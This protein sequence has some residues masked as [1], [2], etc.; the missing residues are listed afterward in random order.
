[1]PGQRPAHEEVEFTSPEDWKK[2]R[3]EAQT[4][5]Q[6]H[7]A[8]SVTTEFVGKNKDV[9]LGFSAF[10]LGFS[11]GLATGLFRSRFITTVHLDRRRRDRPNARRRRTLR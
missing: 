5:H 10:G 2:L 4:Y 7:T 11:A 8:D 1:M 3:S 6:K 9:A